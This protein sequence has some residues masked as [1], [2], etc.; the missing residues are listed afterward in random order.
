MGCL[1][2][3]MIINLF[4]QFRPELLSYCHIQPLQRLTSLI[5]CRG[6]LASIVEII[7]SSF[8]LLLYQSEVDYQLR[9]F[10]IFRRIRPEGIHLKILW[11]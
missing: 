3:V 7:F 4:Y 6:D 9:I 11:G 1:I 2:Y 8:Q 5:D 10:T